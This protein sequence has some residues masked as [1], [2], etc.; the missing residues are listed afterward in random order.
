MCANVCSSVDTSRHAYIYVCTGP[1]DRGVTN[2]CYLWGVHVYVYPVSLYICDVLR[3]DIVYGRVDCISHQCASS[4][5][6]AIT[7]CQEKRKPI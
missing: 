2:V 3:S 6:N 4:T 5:P 7:T 1:G